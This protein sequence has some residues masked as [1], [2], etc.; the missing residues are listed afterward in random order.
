MERRFCLLKLTKL[1]NNTY[2]EGEDLDINAIT[3]K[4]V[5]D[6]NLL[7]KTGVDL[8]SPDPFQKTMDSMVLAMD[9]IERILKKKEK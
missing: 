7:K 2:S 4:L 5:E 6:I 9:E 3:T 1:A 8:T